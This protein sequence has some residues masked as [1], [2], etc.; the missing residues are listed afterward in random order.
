VES[1]QAPGSHIAG[2]AQHPGRTGS[3]QRIEGIVLAH[4]TQIQVAV[5]FTVADHIIAAV[6]IGNIL[7]MDIIM[8]ISNYVWSMENM[9]SVRRHL[10]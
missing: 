4:H 9:C 2:N 6:I 8:N 3:R 1:S 10:H 5:V 7:R